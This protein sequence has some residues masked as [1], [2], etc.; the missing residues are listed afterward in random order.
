MV[1][2]P[3]F[4]F[5][6]LCDIIVSSCFELH[7]FCLGLLIF[8]LWGRVGCAQPPTAVEHGSF[9]WSK[10]LFRVRRNICAKF[11][12]HFPSHRVGEAEI[13]DESRN[14]FPP[15]LDGVGAFFCGITDG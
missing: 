10:W 13:G 6:D 1:E 7:V 9:F 14:V 11:A 2:L 15:P 8:L 5:A 4:F 12:A 3:T